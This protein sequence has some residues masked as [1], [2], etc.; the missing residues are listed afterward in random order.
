MT[1]A[2]QFETM[3]LVERKHLYIQ[4]YEHL[5]NVHMKSPEP[6]DVILLMAML[7]TGSIQDINNVI[8]QLRKEHETS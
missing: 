5:I 3:T 1:A 4:A 2:Q 7:A 8:E 6:A